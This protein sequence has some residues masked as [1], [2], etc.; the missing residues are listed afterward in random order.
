MT[1]KGIH[2][3]SITAFMVV[4]ACR[5]EP[6]SAAPRQPETSGAAS[7]AEATPS[8]P[9][10]RIP[11]EEEMQT[12]LVLQDRVKLEPDD[13]ALRQELVQKAVDL[14]AKVVWSVGRAQLLPQA[15]SSA[16]AKSQAEL[17]GRIEAARWAA[18]LLEWHRNGYATAFG[19][20]HAH[21][22]GNSIVNTIVTDSTCIVLVKTAL[23]R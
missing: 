15:Q 23:E 3:F 22:P 21:V 10:P 7:V 5:Q 19:S 6:D 1:P 9:S 4:T 16:V 17:A 11:T 2:Y 18:H 8:Q 20:I 14:E 12:L 13:L